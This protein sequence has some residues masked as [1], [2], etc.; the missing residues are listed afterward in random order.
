MEKVKNSLNCVAHM[1][2]E[3]EMFISAVLKRKSLIPL[4]NL[5]TSATIQNGSYAK[6]FRWC[7]M[8]VALDQLA[9]VWQRPKDWYRGSACPEY[10]VYLLKVAVR[11]FAP[12]V[13]LAQV[14]QPG[15]RSSEEAYFDSTYPLPYF[16]S[17]PEE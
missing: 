9:V 11:P 12:G 17:S 14:I 8:R 13:V 5:K 1:V 2:Y 4:G 6:C 15:E 7:L 3:Q 10:V 16:C